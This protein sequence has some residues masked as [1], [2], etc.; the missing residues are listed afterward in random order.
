MAGWAA[1]VA[2]VESRWA[3]RCCRSASPY[4]VSASVK[5]AF[6]FRAGRGGAAGVH[7]LMGVLSGSV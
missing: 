1:V 6:A 7:R 2:L 3:G 4:L 5:A